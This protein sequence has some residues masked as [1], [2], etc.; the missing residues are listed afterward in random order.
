MFLNV[1]QSI[2]TQGFSPQS[3]DAPS[4]FRCSVPRIRVKARPLRGGLRPA[5]TRLQGG[6]P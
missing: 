1:E 2:V 5:L 6:I 4:L 3:L